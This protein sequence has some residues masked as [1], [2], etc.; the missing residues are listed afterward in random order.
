MFERFLGFRLFKRFLRFRVG[1][2]DSQRA[3]GL[4]VA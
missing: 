2:L 3:L 1:G 4:S